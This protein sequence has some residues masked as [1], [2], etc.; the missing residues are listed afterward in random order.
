MKALLCN[1]DEKRAANSLV[2]IAAH[3]A[4]RVEQGITLS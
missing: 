2:T 1:A 3:D 4:R